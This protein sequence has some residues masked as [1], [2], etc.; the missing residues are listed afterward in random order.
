MSSLP[1]P[2]LNLHS[3][4]PT[5]LQR[6]SSRKSPVPIKNICPARMKTDSAFTLTVT[7]RDLPF[8]FILRTFT[9]HIIWS[10]VVESVASYCLCQQHLFWGIGLSYCFVQK[11]GKEFKEGTSVS[12]CPQWFP[13]SETWGQ[14]SMLY[15]SDSQSWV[16]PLPP[17]CR[18]PGTSAMCSGIFGCHS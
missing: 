16:I 3:R 8:F 12:H 14:C 5:P 1:S 18:Y 4:L 13:F 17:H 10:Q 9:G 15:S 7:G 11:A 6:H 2:R